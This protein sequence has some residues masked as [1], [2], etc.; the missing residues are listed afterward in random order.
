MFEPTNIKQQQGCVY[1][2]HRNKPQLIQPK[3]HFNRM[4]SET[5]FCKWKF[6]LCVIAVRKQGIIF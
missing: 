2:F 6:V 3:R 5:P 4:D 1:I